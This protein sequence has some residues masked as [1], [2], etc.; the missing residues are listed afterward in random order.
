MDVTISKDFM[1][2]CTTFNMIILIKSF[3]I[4]I[5]QSHVTFRK[6]YIFDRNNFIYTFLTGQVNRF[7]Y[8]EVLKIGDSINIVYIDSF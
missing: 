4:I 8:R 3:L 5:H 6:L 2:K 7:E 1:D